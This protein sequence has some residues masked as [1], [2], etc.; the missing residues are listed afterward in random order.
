MPKLL[1]REEVEG[2]ILD[3]VARYFRIK[4]EEITTE[5]SFVDLF[6]DSLDMVYLPME[7]EGEFGVLLIDGDFDPEAMQTVGDMAD[8]VLGKLNVKQSSSVRKTA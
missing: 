2:R 5:T 8:Y 4:R 3:L 6:A 1:T 7:A